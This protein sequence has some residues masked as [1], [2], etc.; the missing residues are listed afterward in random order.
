MG[1]K[2]TGAL[3]AALILMFSGED[4]MHHASTARIELPEIQTDSG[5]SV[6]EAIEQRRSVREYADTPV[7][8]ADLAQLLW[9]AQGITDPAGLRAAPS[10]GAL[11]PLEVYVVAGNVASLP[12]GVYHYLPRG[13][14]LERVAPEDRRRALAD[15]AL[16]QAPVREAPAVLLMGGVYER[17][18]RKYGQRGIR[19][20]HMEAGHAGQNVFLQAETLG[21]ATVTI[22]A[23]E[24]DGVRKVANLPANVNP[25]YLMPVGHPRE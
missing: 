1:T 21:L 3:L 2:A 11:Y 5:V 18:T 4:A 13:N 23:F 22:G 16:D 19:Y 25:L 12:P 10:A 20:V 14:K 17:T 9:S 15:V 24:D 7:K 8:L 6:E